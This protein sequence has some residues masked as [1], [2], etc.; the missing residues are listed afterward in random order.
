MNIY[1]FRKLQKEKKKLAEH[2]SGGAGP[3]PD[4]LPP[5]PVLLTT[6]VKE[7]GLLILEGNI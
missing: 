5:E 6:Q 3:N 2:I 7:P 4:S 1:I